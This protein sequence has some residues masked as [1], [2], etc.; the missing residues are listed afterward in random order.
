VDTLLLLILYALVVVD[1]YEAF[2][3]KKILTAEPVPISSTEH[4]FFGTR[5]PGIPGIDLRRSQSFAEPVEH[6]KLGNESPYSSR[7]LWPNC[8]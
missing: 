7:M 6:D 8:I 5:T 4:L 3:K 2:W 1:T